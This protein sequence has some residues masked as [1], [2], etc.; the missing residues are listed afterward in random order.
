[1]M[2]GVNRS[3][4]LIGGGVLVGVLLIGYGAHRLSAPKRPE[5]P[6]AVAAP[7]PSLVAARPIAR[8]RRIEPGD[9]MLTALP[10]PPAGALHSTDA[11]I[12]RIAVADIAPRQP[13]LGSALAADASAL[14][15]AALVPI[16][17]RAISIQT[18]D[19]IAVSNLLRPGDVVDVQMVLGDAV[20]AKGSGGAGGDRSE[21][22]TL[23]QAVRVVSVGEM[24]ARPGAGGGRRPEPA[25]TM[26]LAMTPEQVAQ[27][28]LARSL[29]AFYL[30][31][32]NPADDAAPP[33]VA[34]RL[35]DLRVSA[36][37]VRA[38][39]AAA[40]PVRPRPAAAPPRTDGIEL[41][42]GGRSQVIYPQ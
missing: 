7:G 18:N 21:A 14:G 5:P 42:V 40:R 36:P 12:G 17:Y 2:S 8:G 23:L 25:R 1:M 31:L 27:F 16:G 11:A 6:A 19:E 20:L 10:Q 22:S 39:V 32:R 37:A 3:T 33:R 24:L 13:V 4:A 38:A 30:A 29:G 15:L 34:A 26:T 41:V 28:T 9:L 35:P